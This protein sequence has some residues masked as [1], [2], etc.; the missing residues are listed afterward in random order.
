[1]NDKRMLD[2]FFI[3]KLTKKGKIAYWLIQLG[4]DV[5]FI[6]SL[7]FIFGY[8]SDDLFRDRYY[9]L[10]LGV[11]VAMFISGGICL[12]FWKKEEES[13]KEEA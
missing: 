7:I 6:L 9:V 2:R 3:E 12:A 8:D 10:I 1:M 4:L 5:V 11:L 13:D